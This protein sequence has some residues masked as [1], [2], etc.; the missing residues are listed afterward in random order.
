MFGELDKY[1]I[2]DMS[3]LIMD[4]TAGTTKVCFSKK[5]GIVINDD[6]GSQKE[7][8]LDVSDNDYID[9]SDTDLVLVSEDKV[10]VLS[11]FGVLYQME[12]DNAQI[13]V[14]NRC[15]EIDGEKFDKKL[16]RIDKFEI[17]YP[18]SIVNGHLA[19][20]DKVT[21][22]RVEEDDIYDSYGGVFVLVKSDS[23]TLLKADGM[24]MALPFSR[25]EDYDVLSLKITPNAILVKTFMNGKVAFSL[26]GY[27]E[28]S[29]EQ[30]IIRNNSIVN[31]FLSDDR[32]VLNYQN[33]EGVF[34][35]EYSLA[36][37]GSFS[38]DDGIQT[39]FSAEKTTFFIY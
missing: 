30:I 7:V 5:S 9:T 4:Y 14:T 12:L 6:D 28:E 27:D 10:Q 19:F 20:N 22:I 24:C 8:A 11:I 15:I 36:K 25:E 26:F 33:G 17:G 35:M 16:Q 3:G 39:G 1:V 29:M 21:N 31:A 2:P 37:N 34:A 32:L 38:L 23:V 18:F 13:N